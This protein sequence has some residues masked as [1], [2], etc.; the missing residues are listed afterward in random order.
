MTATAR[1]P[2]A[3]YRSAASRGPAVLPAAEARTLTD[4]AG[5]PGR[6]P[7]TLTGPGELEAE[8]ERVRARGFAVDDEENEPTIRCV[9]AA[10]SGPAGRPVGG[11]SVT[12]V[13]FL[14][15][16]DELESYA[17]AVRA[18]AEA[19]APLL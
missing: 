7:N 13:T 16:L 2:S 10:V 18:A 8:L 15:G 11:V 4:A 12:T 9:G 14:T 17:P 3:R 1:A 5:L 19:L 6:T